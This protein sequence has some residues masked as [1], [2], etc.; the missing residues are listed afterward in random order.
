MAGEPTERQRALLD[1]IRKLDPERRHTLT[2]VCRGT[3]PW[4]IERVV[5][6]M[7]IELKPEHKN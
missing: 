4:R 7:E 1:V 3:E 5:E 6:H 2:I